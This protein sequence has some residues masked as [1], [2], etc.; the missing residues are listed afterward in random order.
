MAT[1]QGKPIKIT[2]IHPDEL[3]PGLQPHEVSLLRLLESVTNGSAIEISY[4]GT[5]LIYRPGLII[6]GSFNHNCPNNTSI[7]YYLLPML[8]L[9]PFSKN[10]FSIIFKGLT[11]KKGEP[12]LDFVKWAYLP[13]LDK[14]GIKDVELHTLKRGCPPLAGGE[15]HLIINSR[16][17][18]PI[19]IHALEIPKISTIRGIAWCARVSP[20]VVNRLVDSARSILR[21]T[22]CDVNI[23][24][25]VWRGE[26][27]GKSP[28]FGLTLFSECKKSPLRYVTDDVGEAGDTPEDIGT[29]V[30]Y[31]LL[32]E[33]ANSGAT[34]RNQLE[35]AFILMTIGKEDIG[36]FIIN[37]S[38]MDPKLVSHLRDIKNVFG[39]EFFFQEDD[40]ENCLIATCKG[41]GFTNASKK[42]A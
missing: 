26:N 28:G 10:K 41:V 39:T 22:G 18:Q 17:P 42:I 27:S 16:I 40:D 29:R 24:T 34:S 33:I 1:L 15:V 2:N 8:L 31:Q 12:G 7:S 35:A 13:M 6:G 20:S 38:Q 11:S 21:P 4:T 37:K 14:F 19:T 9:G 36:R 23:T 30:A 32:E 25:D 5:T 3:N